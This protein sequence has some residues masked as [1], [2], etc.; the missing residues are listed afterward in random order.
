MLGP[1]VFTALLEH[2][3]AHERR[4]SAE[5]GREGSEPWAVR[6]GLWRLR[7]GGGG[8]GVGQVAWK[9]EAVVT[10]ARG[11]LR[12][13][14]EQDLRD[15]GPRGERTLA[16]GAGRTDHRGSRKHVMRCEE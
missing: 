12:R 13:V 7:Q 4:G 2:C 15:V 5:S 1:G 6:R 11:Q 3:L 10:C 14:V 16:A 9:Q 8:H